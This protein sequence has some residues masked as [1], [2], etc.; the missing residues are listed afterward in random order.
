[1]ADIR[2]N[3][4]RLHVKKKITSEIFKDIDTEWGG[5]ESVNTK[6]KE[7]INKII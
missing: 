5:G 7:T 1:M 4:L 2:S 3:I 6:I